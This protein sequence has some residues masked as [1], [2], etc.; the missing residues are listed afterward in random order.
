MLKNIIKLLLIIIFASICFIKINDQKETKLIGKYINNQTK[1]NYLNYEVL[2]IPKINLLEKIE[3]NKNNFSNLDNSLVYYE[4]LN[5]NNRIIIF[6][7]SG[8]GYNTYFNRLDEL[9]I[10]DYAYLYY[11][12]YKIEYLLKDIYTVSEY[13]TDIMNNTNN[14]QKL[15]LITCVK[16]KKDRRLV[17]KF[18]I[19]GIK[20]IEK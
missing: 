16:N 12:N 4:D 7:H 2:E 11:D 18:D 1:Y 5:Y 19:K 10:N 15:I 6:G 8:M 17:L 14:K 13:E 20:N 3:K 9:K